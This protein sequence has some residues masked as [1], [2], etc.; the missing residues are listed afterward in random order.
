ME[1]TDVLLI[2]VIFALVEVLKYLKV[3]KKV[4]PIAS[5]VLGVIMGLA[6]SGFYSSG[7]TVIEKDVK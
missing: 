4:L 2:G 5:L 3:P 6:A 7:K 1:Y